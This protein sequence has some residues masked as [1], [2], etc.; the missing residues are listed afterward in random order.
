ML[1]VLLIGVVARDAAA[2]DRVDL[3]LVLL[4]D[5]SRSIDDDEIRFQRQGYAAAITHPDVLAAI[6]HGFERRIAVTYVEWGDATSQEV[7]V[8]WTI[9]DGA[10]S[11]GAFAE[12]LLAEPRRATGP[13]AIGSALAAAH[14]LIDGNGIDGTRKVIDF[15][16]DSAYSA[17]GVLIHEARAA[18]IAA[19][20]TI[21]G[22]AI[23]CR[24]CSS[25]RP[26][27]YD[28]E[29]AFAAFVVGG[30]GSFVVTADGDARFAQAVRRKLILEIA[31]LRLPMSPAAFKRAPGAAPPSATASPSRLGRSLVMLRRR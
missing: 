14:A 23:L 26:I 19:G 31:G 30:D 25:G 16:A 7:V 2:Q 6:S 15:S 22:L 28:L 8:P 11:A 17:G 3:E 10:D 18:A 21:N 4:A 27:D 9:V 29:S 5:A 20:I 24:D 12:R 1:L 13:N